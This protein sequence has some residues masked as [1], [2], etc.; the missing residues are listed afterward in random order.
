MEDRSSALRTK[1]VVG[2]VGVVLSVFGYFLID[3]DV[4]VRRNIATFSKELQ[5]LA[6]QSSRNDI[7]LDELTRRTDRIEDTQKTRGERLS[8]LE[9]LMERI[10]GTGSK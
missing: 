10:Q 4:E 1:F 5:E 9:A 6:I 3:R 8:R 7:R 2:S